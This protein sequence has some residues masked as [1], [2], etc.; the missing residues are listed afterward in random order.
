[1]FCARRLSNPIARPVHS[2]IIILTVAGCSLLLFDR[3]SPTSASA[4]FPPSALSWQNL[5]FSLWS[6][7]SL[8]G[9]LNGTHPLTPPELKILGEIVYLAILLRIGLFQLTFSNW[10]CTLPGTEVR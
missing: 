5:S 7:E 9:V 10:Q 2:S 6:K 1:M 3:F 4:R 8:W